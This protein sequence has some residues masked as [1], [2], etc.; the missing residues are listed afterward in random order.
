M[1]QKTGSWKEPNYKVRI[2]SGSGAS[3]EHRSSLETEDEIKAEI[4]VK[5]KVE[6]KFKIDGDMFMELDVRWRW[7][8]A[9]SKRLCQQMHP[10]GCHKTNKMNCGRCG[11][12]QVVQTKCACILRNLWSIGQD[13]LP[14]QDTQI[15][16]Q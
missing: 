7:V 14:E 15:Q 1:P 11:Y 12:Q 4:Q 10:H 8:W 9:V 3:A 16:K 13:A 5:V 6:I 2:H